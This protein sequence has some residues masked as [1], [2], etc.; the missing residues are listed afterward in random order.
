MVEGPVPGAAVRAAA[1]AISRLLFS[2]QPE[3]GT[4]MEHDEDLARAAVEAAAPHLAAD[5]DLIVSD[6]LTAAGKLLDAALAERDQLRALVERDQFRALAE[7]LYTTVPHDYWSPNCRERIGPSPRLN[8]A[9]H[10]PCDACVLA[11]ELGGALGEHGPERN[12]TDT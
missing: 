11:E 12:G 8:I 3:H 4:W 1:D 2:G 7:R 10:D 6:A 5:P 9:W